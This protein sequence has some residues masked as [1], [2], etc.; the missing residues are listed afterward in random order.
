MSTD[1]DGTRLEAIELAQED[2]KKTKSRKVTVMRKV[3][4]LACKV[5]M[6]NNWH[7]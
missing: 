6:M 2:P 5:K 7:D 3:Q 4:V 1:E